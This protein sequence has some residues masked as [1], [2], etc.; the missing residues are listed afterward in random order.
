MGEL[1]SAKIK[2][3]ILVVIAIF[4]LDFIIN[5]VRKY[6]RS[7]K[8]IKK[9]NRIWGKVPKKKYID[10]DFV[11]LSDFLK[12]KMK[13]INF[14]HVIDDITWNDINMK[15][16]FMRI[17]TTLSTLGENVLYFMLK[18]PVFNKEILNKRDEYIEFFSRDKEKRVKLQNIIINIGEERSTNVINYI[19]T[20]QPSNTKKKIAYIILS[21]IFIISIIGILFGSKYFL[22]VFLFSAIT[23]VIVYYKTGEKRQDEI[24]I[25]KYVS[26]IVLASKQIC[27]LDYSEINEYNLRLKTAYK[28][29]KTI[30]FKSSVLLKPLDLDLVSFLKVFLLFELIVYEDLISHIYRNR[31]EVMETYEAIGY[32]DALISI[33]SYRES[34]EYYAKPELVDT[35]QELVIDCEDIYHPLIDNPVKN[36]ISTGESIL[37]TGSNATGKSTFIKTVAINS[38]LAQT[39]YTC[40]AT[41]YKSNYFKTYTSMALQ[42]NLL[43]NESYFMVE[44][45]SL[46][47]ILNNLDKDIPILCFIDEILRGT[48]TIERIAAS[49]QVLKYLGNQNCLCFAATHDIELTDILKNYY[50]NYHFQER[51]VDNEV[52]FDYKLYKDKTKSR[53]AI[54]LLEITGYDKKI[55]DDALLSI[56]E[57]TN[58]N[59]WITL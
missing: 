18:T 47:R 25:V 50:V 7:K 42:D 2:L 14:T 13:T 58:N 38:I 34:L 41:K 20:E 21:A 56:D 10:S 27:K 4:A 52:I 23:N 11:I 6:Q 48:N 9:I 12:H 51:I 55:I 19:L 3:V 44:I 49:S 16:I 1:L 24:Q 36:S 28:K 29:L 45:K 8:N 46:K 5:S 33:A 30:H 37:L 15:K 32:I 59:E 53:N 35:N 40:S 17:N 39:I 54:K 31:E 22:A 57:Y 43:N 26:K